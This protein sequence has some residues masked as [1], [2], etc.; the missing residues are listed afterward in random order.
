[1]ELRARIRPSRRAATLAALGAVVASAAAGAVATDAQ[2]AKRKPVV[3]SISPKSVAVN[4]VLTVHGK[5]FLRGRA[6]NT[7]VFKRAGAKAVFV[8]ADVS[9][10]RMLRVTIPER[11]TPVMAIQDGSPIPTLFKIRILAKRFGKSFTGERLSPFV[12]P[13]L[14]P[15]PEKP[16]VDPQGDCDSDGQLNNVD[17]DDDNDLLLDTTEKGLPFPTDPCKYDTDGD[18]IGDGYEYRSARDL[19]NDE[20]Q[21]LNA[22]L[23]FPGKKP[24]PN[25][26]DASDAN[27]DF[28][29]DVLT[30]SEEHRLWKYTL[31]HGAAAPT[32]E[33]LE[34]PGPALTYSDGM[35]YSAYKFV[36]GDDRRVPALAALNY[37]KEL[38]FKAWL[39]SSGYW[40]IHRPDGGDGFLLDVNRDGVISETGTGARPGPGYWSS[41]SHYLDISDNGWLSD[42][43]RDEDGDGLSN[44]VESHG[45]LQPGFWL[46]WYPTETAF[47]IH[48]E[49]TEVDD[50]DTDGDGVLDGADDQDHDDYPNLVEVSRN[51]VS[52]R[53]RDPKDLT[54][55]TA[56]PNPWYGRVQPFNPCMPLISS[57]TC[58]TYVS[59]NEFSPFTD[60]DINYGVYN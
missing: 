37:D 17:A 57:R 30:L 51:A 40:N 6:K 19:N 54:P 31:A 56:N 27:I 5:Y 24:Y 25:P 41:E 53:Q 29:G 10:K 49:G 59:P 52:G 21:N 18:S 4:Q 7:V 22:F 42:D 44:Y 12:G 15:A 1:M 26:L 36:A 14:P 47:R 39:Q 32:P 8:K 20:Y 16:V 35:K 43:E 60:Q 38:S 45:P 9:T 23:P 55:A 3:T 48:Y 34:A 2:A 28:D 58:P 33:Q 13:E 11:M 46:A 50:P